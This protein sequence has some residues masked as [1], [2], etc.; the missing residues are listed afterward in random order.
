VPA[1]PFFTRFIA[2]DW[3]GAR[4]PTAQRRAIACCVVERRDHGSRVVCLV[5][6]RDRQETVGWLAERAT[7]GVPT[8]AGLDFPF[9]YAAPFLDH[10]GARDFSALLAC[11]AP[12]DGPLAAPGGV[13]EFVGT[14]GQWWA[15]GGGDA[16]RRTRR[17]V[18]CRPETRNAE[19]P[20]RALL[21][22]RGYGFVGARQVGKAAITGIAAIAALK[23]RAPN[24]RVWPFERL[25]GA[26]LVLAEIW[27]RL[28][29]G[30][31]TKSDPAARR[32]KVRELRRSG[33]RLRP[34]HA[35]MAEESD[36]A[37]D[38]LATA[39]EMASGRWPL[40]RRSA[41][42]PESAREGWILGVEPRG[43]RNARD[44]RQRKER[45]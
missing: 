1:G 43:P 28:A 18:E 12:L 33:V 29:L 17:Q 36:H 14:C 3:S 21:T 4:E 7:D 34:E 40:S 10:L 2:I 38:A 16:D 8:L 44:P 22:P 39:V 9:A 37:I 20:L 42:P 23:R 26:S 32:H 35:R 5:N 30:T 45:A 24:V 25:G 11:M 13:D 6:G 31:L 41:L 15:C 19:S 27:P